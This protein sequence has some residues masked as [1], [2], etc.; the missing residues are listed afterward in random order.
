[1]VTMFPLPYKNVQQRTRENCGRNFHFSSQYKCNT[2]RRPFFSEYG[3]PGRAIFD[4]SYHQSLY[5]TDCAEAVE[6][7]CFRDTDTVH[8]AFPEGIVYVALGVH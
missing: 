5:V 4:M 8:Y 1:M 2:E 6:D 7:R 3:T